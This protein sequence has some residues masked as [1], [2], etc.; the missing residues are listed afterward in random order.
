MVD[1]SQLSVIQSALAHEGIRGALARLNA[2]SSYRFTAMYMFD[3]Q[4][5]QNLYFYDRKHPEIS[6]AREMD[7]L[8]VTVTYCVYVRKTGQ[9]FVVEDALRDDQLVDH[10]SRNTIR[11]Y[12]GVPLHGRLGQI[13]GTLCHFDFEPISDDESHVSLMESL[14]TVIDAETCHPIRRI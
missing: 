8:P 3:G 9:P 14:S 1:S 2:L 7:E 13:F 5:V 10:P 12:C 6:D 11:A 4:R